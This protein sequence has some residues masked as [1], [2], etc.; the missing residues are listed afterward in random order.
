[1]NP[2]PG[3]IPG[4]PCA[5]AAVTRHRPGDGGRGGIGCRLV[6][7]PCGMDN[8]PSVLTGGIERWDSVSQVKKSTGYQSDLYK[9]GQ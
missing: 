6:F 7:V 4:L 1:M 8:D 2:G 9:A 3:N 5:V